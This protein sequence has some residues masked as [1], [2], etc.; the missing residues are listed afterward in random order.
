MPS[1]FPPNV[2]NCFDPREPQG[3]CGNDLPTTIRFPQKQEK[4][5]C[6]SEGKQTLYH[7]ARE[8][9]LGRENGE[10]S[11]LKNLGRLP[12]HLFCHSGIRVLMGFDASCRVFR[13][14]EVDGSLS[15]M[16]ECD[17]PQSRRGKE[18]HHPTVW[19]TRKDKRQSSQ[20]PLK[21]KKSLPQ[22][23]SIRGNRV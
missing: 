23:N 19:K 22:D 3:P 7:V 21:I 15:I 1:P 2:R 4:N 11:I 5:K 10:T 17:P 20:P 13:G 16:Q 8:Y 9:Q 6:R 12:I 18:K 14:E